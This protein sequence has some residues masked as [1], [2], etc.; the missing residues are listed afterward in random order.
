[1]YTN[2]PPQ[3]SYSVL[4][5]SFKMHAAN[6]IFASIATINGFLHPLLNLGPEGPDRIAGRMGFPVGSFW[7]HKPKYQDTVERS[8]V[9]TEIKGVIADMANDAICS[10]PCQRVSHFIKFEEVL[11][12]KGLDY[13]LRLVFKIMLT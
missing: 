12:K 10:Y 9:R 6:I 2:L 7:T 4:A 3:A 8:S 5:I 13:D 1:M 11:R